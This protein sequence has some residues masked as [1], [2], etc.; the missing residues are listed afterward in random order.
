MKKIRAIGIFLFVVF[1]FSA[2]MAYKTT[3]MQ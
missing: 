3:F 2:Y 1:L